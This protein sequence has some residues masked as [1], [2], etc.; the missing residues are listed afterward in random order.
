MQDSGCPLRRGAR[1]AGARGH[2]K[3]YEDSGDAHLILADRDSFECRFG[4]VQEH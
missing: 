2:R 1:P 3:A 4:F